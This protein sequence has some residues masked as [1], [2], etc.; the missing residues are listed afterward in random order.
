MISPET[1]N[2]LPEK[3]QERFHALS[4][5]TQVRMVE[6]PRIQEWQ[7]LARESGFDICVNCKKIF[8]LPEMGSHICNGNGNG[9]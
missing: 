1:L 2:N 9:R 6:Q 3:M 5:V 8:S 4:I 7:K